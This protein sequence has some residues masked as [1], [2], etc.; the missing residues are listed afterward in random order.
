MMEFELKFQVCAEQRA[1]VAKAVRRGRSRQTRLRAAYF[2]TPDGRL[3]AHGIALRLRLEGEQ[4]VQTAKARGGS[5]LERH[6]HNVPRDFAAGAQPH[7]DVSLHAGTPVGKLLAKALG[8][9]DQAA[10][11]TAY[12]TDVQRTTREIRD[13]NTTVE[14]AF[15]QGRIEAGAS[16]AELCELEFELKQGDAWV[17]VELARGWMLR[18]LLWLDTLSKAARGERLAEGRAS[19]APRK[20]EPPALQRGMTGP[21]LLRAVVACCLAQILPNAS[22]VAG[23]A[24]KAE[25]VHQLRVGVRRLRTALRELAE[26]GP[27][28]DPAW[29]PV[30]SASFSA[31]GEHRDRAHQREQV[32]PKLQA[33]GGPHIDWDAGRPAPADPKETVRA[34]EFQGVLLDLLRFTLVAPMP[35]PNAPLPGSGRDEVGRRMDALHRKVRKE[36]KRFEQLEPELR[37]RLRKRAKRLRYLAEFIAPLYPAKASAAFMAALEPVQDALGAHNDTAVALD[38]ARKVA[39]HDPHAWFAVGWL[40][41]Q[42][43]QEV[44]ACCKA[45]RKIGK[46]QPFWDSPKKK[47]R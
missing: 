39:A 45:L 44:A 22:D 1:D 17:V 20:A 27:G 6:E 18:H 46:A 28:I 14:L 43:D 13:G 31:L 5:E 36:S 24:G 19:G 26:L 15:D 12:G 35:D 47:K 8:K 21:A 41:A 32:Q 11:T 42:H 10:L 16:V 2:D 4:W 9:S 3:A 29:E 23:G 40:G 33:A 38:V 25:H 7:P 30:L 34:A 37:H